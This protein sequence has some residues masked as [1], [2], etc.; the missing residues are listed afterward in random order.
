MWAL[1]LVVTLGTFEAVEFRPQYERAHQVAAT[2]AAPAVR[3]SETLDSVVLVPKPVRSDAVPTG[4]AAF[5]WQPGSWA[6]METALAVS[7]TRSGGG[8]TVEGDAA[9]AAP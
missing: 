5:K 7:S 6:A 8:G 4:N 1:P 2:S 9:S 3:P